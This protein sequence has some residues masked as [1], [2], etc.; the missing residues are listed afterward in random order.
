MIIDGHLQND[1][2]RFGKEFKEVHEYLDQFHGTPCFYNKQIHNLEH[3]THMY[4]EG[5]WTIEEYRAALFHLLDDFGM[6]LPLRQD[7]ES[8]KH[9]LGNYLNKKKDNTEAVKCYL[10]KIKKKVRK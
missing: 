4:E 6:D 3:I 5:S 8:D 1:R 2:K 7:W 9:W 10:K